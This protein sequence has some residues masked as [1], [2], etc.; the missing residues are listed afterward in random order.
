MAQKLLII[1]DQKGVARV[2]ELAAAELGYETRIETRPEEAAEAFIAFRP[3]VV[4]LDMIMPEKD[5]IDVLQELLL[6]GSPFRLILT[7][8]F[9]TGYLQLAEQVARFHGK[10]GVTVLR[11]PFRRNDLRSALRPEW[12]VISVRPRSAAP[13]GWQGFAVV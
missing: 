5:G 12:S 3:D 6:I 10:T 13:A 9:S 8:G 11:K 1:D 2:V 4:M 7:S